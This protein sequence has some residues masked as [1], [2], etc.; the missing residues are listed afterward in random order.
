MRRLLIP[1][2]AVSA[3]AARGAEFELAGYR[4]DASIA[5]EALKCGAD[6]SGIA[7]ERCEVARP[8]TPR[9]H[10]VA[11]M[12]LTLYV[13]DNKI[14]AV[15]AQLPEREFQ[16]VL[17]ALRAEHGPGQVVREKLRAGMGG[18]FENEIVTWPQAAATLRA[19]QFFR[20]IDR[21]AVM[22]APDRLLPLLV[23]PK[24][25]ENEMGIKDL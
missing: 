2:L 15:A 13:G 4:L 16:R 11:L 5:T 19:E 1:L 3:F 14:I 21:S 6:T 22:L 17:T 8:E 24:S 20:K 7:T 25:G 23:P 10:G 12:S 18:V 9:W